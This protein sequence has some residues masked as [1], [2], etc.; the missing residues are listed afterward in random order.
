MNK[1][2]EN[3][4][5]RAKKYRDAKVLIWSKKGYGSLPTKIIEKIVPILFKN[6]AIIHNVNIE[7][8]RITSR[9]PKCIISGRVGLFNNVMEV[10]N[11]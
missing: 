7:G 5:E 3:L 10:A 6:Y 4:E 2:I 8:A 9:K 11:D 1:E